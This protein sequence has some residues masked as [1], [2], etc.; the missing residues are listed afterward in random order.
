MTATQR[1]TAIA[2]VVII[3]AAVLGVAWAQRAAGVGDGGVRALTSGHGVK[4]RF[5]DKPV[6][7]PPFSIQDVNGRTMTPSDWKG[8]VVLI[9]FWATWCGPCRQEIPE[10]VALQ[11][12]YKNQLIVVG[13]SIDER[14]AADVKAFAAQ[15][16]I[17]YPVAIADQAL[18]HAFGGLTAVPATFVVNADGGI[19]QRHVGVLE[20]EQTE[21][22][23]RVLARLPSPAQVDIVPDTGQVLIANAA[24]A[25]EI[26]GLDLSSVTPT[27]KETILKRLNTESCT[28]GCGRTLAQCRIEDPTCSVS[29]PAAKKVA[30]EVVAGK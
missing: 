8:K 28:C 19:V 9:N 11:E 26:P 24:Y 27:Q 7:V 21:H 23:V 6:S 14:P 22:E 2:V 25:T 10:L 29:L 3:L 1:T 16:G 15:V 12:H 30:A 5:S 17:N 13:L 20:P 4:I 18:Q